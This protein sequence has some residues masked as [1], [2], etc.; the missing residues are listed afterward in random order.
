MKILDKY[1]LIFKDSKNGSR[2]TMIYSNPHY[3][4]MP[5]V[6][7]ENRPNTLILLACPKK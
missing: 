4:N 3:N 2:M 1:K 7:G 6:G 5:L